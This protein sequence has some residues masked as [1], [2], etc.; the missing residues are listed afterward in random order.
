MSNQSNAFLSHF[1]LPVVATVAIVSGI[2]CTLLIWSTGEVDSISEARQGQVVQTV[3]SQSMDR[4]AHDQEASTVWDDAVLEVRSPQP[5]QEWLDNNLGIW[6]HTYYGYDDIYI[7]DPQDQPIYGMHEGKRTAPSSFTDL[8]RDIQPLI[9]ELRQ[10]TRM[11]VDQRGRLNTKSPGASDITV[12]EGRPSII[13]V[14]PIVSETGRYPQAPG[15]EYLHIS[16]RHIDGTFL[17]N[18][19]R[20]YLIDDARFNWLPEHA[21]GESVDALRSRSGHIVGY[22]IWRSFSPGARVMSDIAPALIA[23]LTVIALIVALLL[24]RIRRTLQ[25]LRASEAQA[26]HLAFHDTLTGL[27]NRALF[28][29]RLDHALAAVRRGG[30]AVALFYLDLDRFKSV[31]DTLGHPAGDMLIR[32]VAGR[33]KA[34]TRETDTV[35]RLGGDE[36]AIIQADGATTAAAEILCLRL[37]ETMCEPFDLEGVRVSV[38]VSIGVAVAPVHGLDR[39]ELSRKADIALYEAKANGRGRYVLFTE[40]M[41]AS[42]KHRQAIERD[43]REA[44]AA[45]GQLELHFQPIHD[46]RSCAPVGAEALVRWRHPREGM[47]SPVTFIPI[48][49]ECGLIEPLGEW[50]LREACLAAR[51]ADVP[52]VSVNV[53]A[54]QLRNAGFAD[55]VRTIIAAAGL[56]PQRLELEIT[57]TSFVENEL[58]CQGNVAALRGQGIRIALDDFGT[59]YSSLNHLRNFDVD[60]LKVDR[61]FVSAIDPRQGGSAIIQAIVDLADARGIVVTAEGVETAEQAEWLARIGCDALQGYLL[62]RPMPL[63]LL[64]GMFTASPPRIANVAEG[65]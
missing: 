7:V 23:A 44:L 48:A 56:E 21:R 12:I 53:S 51:Q 58:I 20:Q 50:V 2:V 27:A 57:E 22:V 19:A 18:L 37:V 52:I 35:A 32:Q 33:L 38:G 24:I 25:A 1:L 9:D 3:I 29:D 47:L 10:K 17:A 28:E 13:S 41:D 8:R 30:Q 16:I 39:I 4:I 46:A 63:N 31:N 34:F 54:V 40:A 43:L 61:S 5:D 15:R 42:I 60:R 14:K 49:E 55:R 62:S 59:G 11:G 36:F 64:R 65:V 6:F 26:Q 45:G